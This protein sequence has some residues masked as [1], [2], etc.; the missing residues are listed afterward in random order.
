VAMLA[1]VP[2]EEGTAVGT[3]VLR[4]AEALG[5]VGPVLERLELRLGERV[6]VRDAWSR[7]ALRD[8]EVGVQMRDQPRTGESTEPLLGGR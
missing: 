4:G 7:V 2:V 6:V 3:A 8:A 5:K 1:V